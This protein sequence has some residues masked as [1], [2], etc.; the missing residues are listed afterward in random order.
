MDMLAEN[1]KI[2]RA[3]RKLRYWMGATMLDWFITITI[4]TAI[5]LV[6]HN[7]WRARGLII[8]RSGNSG[9][10]EHFLDN[11]RIGRE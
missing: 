11:K 9:R 2:R 4:L 6:A 5:V 10:R 1:T 7:L 3:V 8:D